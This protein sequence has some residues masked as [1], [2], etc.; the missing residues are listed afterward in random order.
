MRVCGW[1]V[2]VV[3]VVGGGG[4]G[5]GGGGAKIEKVNLNMYEADVAP[6]PNDRK[7]KET[8]RLRSFRGGLQLLEHFNGVCAAR[9][10]INPSLRPAH[11]VQ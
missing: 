11:P 10:T 1:V 8:C 9:H 7:G 4:G 6:R 3:V 2:V 5:G